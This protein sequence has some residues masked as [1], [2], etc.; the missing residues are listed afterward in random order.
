VERGI[1]ID[2][3]REALEKNMKNRELHVLLNLGSGN[4]SF[5]VWTCDFSF[6]YVKINSHYS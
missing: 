3:P 5:Q 1:A 4:A 6:D 2:V